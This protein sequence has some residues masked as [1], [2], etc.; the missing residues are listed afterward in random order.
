MSPTATGPANFRF[1][2]LKPDQPDPK[3]EILK[4]L[5]ATPKGLPPHLFYD[6]PGAELFVQIVDQPEY[7]PPQIERQIVAQ[8]GAEISMV[9]GNRVCLLEPGAGDCAKVQQHLDQNPNIVR[10]VPFE[11][12]AGMLERTARQV[13]E[14]HPD[15]QVDA[16]AVDY[17][18][19]FDFPVELAESN[20]NIVVY[21]P[22]SS[23]GNYEPKRAVEVIKRFREFAGPEASLFIGVDTVKDPATL[24]AAYN[25]AAGVTAAFNLNIIRH[26]ARRPDTE[27]N[28]NDFAHKAFF[29]EKMSRIEMHLEVR[30]TH[31]TT[32]CG[33]PFTFTQG[34][35]LHTENSYKYTPEA[36]GEM[37]LREAGFTERRVFMDDNAQF[38]YHFFKP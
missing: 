37:I 8:H 4:G 21:F 17:L 38:S 24:E 30:R 19:P 32:V 20:E 18:K 29:N 22:G 12:S 2:D 34:E 5:R 16:I 31:S 25:D 13:A 28:V 10:Y 23:I 14:N 36:F 26:L 33:Q 11:I 35:T 27:L 6:E 3:P 7:Y 1:F 9:L 15:V